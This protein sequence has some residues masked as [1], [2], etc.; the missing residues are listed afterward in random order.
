MDGQA[1]IDRFVEQAALD[2]GR[3]GGTAA[4]MPEPGAALGTEGA[5]QRVSRIRNPGSEPGRSP[6]EMQCRSRHHAG[7][8]N[9]RRGLF[10]ALGN[11]RRTPAAG[12][13]TSR[14]GLHHT[15]SRREGDSFQS[16]WFVR[17]RTRRR[18]LPCPGG[19][20]VVGFLHA[21]HGAAS[22]PRPNPPPVPRAPAYRGRRAA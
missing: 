8:A 4:L 5:V 20:D 16:T 22:P 6:R 9:G 13:A 12:H 11:G 17:P 7:D 1:K 21:I 15:G 3:S 18:L 2:V 10:A 19:G 14:S